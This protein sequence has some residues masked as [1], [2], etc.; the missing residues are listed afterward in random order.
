MIDRG[1][2]LN[3]FSEIFYKIKFWKELNYYLLLIN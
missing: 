1:G 2:K 3:Y